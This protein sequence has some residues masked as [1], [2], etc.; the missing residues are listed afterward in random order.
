[1]RVVRNIAASPEFL[2]E[3]T[4][5]FDF[6]RQASVGDGNAKRDPVVEPSKPR[7]LSVLGPGLITG[8]AD[9]D[10]S[11]IATY[12]Q[13][14]AQFGYG[15]VWTM[16]FCYPLMAAVQIITARLGR[17]TGRG[18]AGNIR[19]YYP[20]WIV[21][22]CVTLL[23]IANIIN[24]G[25]DIGAMADAV[26]GLIGGSI[27]LYVLIFG[28]VS[29][30]M[31]VLLEYKQYVRILKWLTLALFTYI[32]TLFF[33]KIDWMALLH[34]TAFPP[35]AFNSAY[36]TAIV[37]IV[38]TT[39]SP[40]LFF[41]QSSQEVEDIKEKPE[42]E[43]LKDAPEQARGA[44]QRINLDT[45]V[46]MGFSTIIAL[47]IMVTAAA[48]LHKSGITQIESS[49]QAAEA[50]KPI[51]GSFAQ[52]LFVLGILGTG[53]LAVP[54]LGGS[55]AY[56][57]G[58]TL[59]WPTGLNRKPKEAKA[60]YA[61]IALAT[62]IGVGLDFTPINPMQALYWSAVING[63][64]AVPVMIIMM[65]MATQPRIM[66]EQTIGL[67][68]KIFGWIATVFMALAAIAMIAMNVIAF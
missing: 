19:R 12:S 23:V 7:L 22:I 13:T 35:I 61:T 1:M 68:L 33:V 57:V 65:L 56:G 3:Q 9:D 54:V 21:Y 25:A 11:G 14:G 51:A 42:R 2:A 64:V 55:A 8:A 58:E 43:P 4:R 66:G 53:L 34:D 48:T 40:Y 24:I 47:A 6:M 59:K 41:W 44:E 39:I 10:P 29:I 67:T 50:L 5:E 18:L 31:Q 52:F 28:S 20:S 16:P 27:I 38:G 36:L 49:A 15:T 46:G 37:A 63:V 45:L 60:F 30:L 26:S 32:G 17:T 62:A